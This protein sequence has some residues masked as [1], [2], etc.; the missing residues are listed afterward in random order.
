[1]VTTRKQLEPPPPPSQPKNERRSSRARKPVELLVTSQDW[2]EKKSTQAALKVNPTITKAKNGKKVRAKHKGFTIHVLSLDFLVSNAFFFFPHSF[3]SRIITITFLIHACIPFHSSRNPNRVLRNENK[4]QQHHL[5]GDGERAGTGTTTIGTASA[6]SSLPNSWS[7]PS[8]ASRSGSGTRIYRT[9]RQRRGLGGRRGRDRA[10]SWSR[11]NRCR[12]ALPS[13]SAP[14]RP[15]LSWKSGS[16]PGTGAGPGGV[17]PPSWTVVAPPKVRTLS[18]TGPA[19]GSNWRPFR[20]LWTRCRSRLDS[21]DI[22]PEVEPDDPTAVGKLSNY[23]NHQGR[24]WYAKQK[25]ETR[26]RTKKRKRLWMHICWSC[27]ICSKG[28]F[29]A[30]RCWHGTSDG[31]FLSHLSAIDGFRRS[32]SRLRR[33][34]RLGSMPSSFASKRLF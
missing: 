21:R 34:N 4:K 19:D 14:R 24:S 16:C 20:T 28:K 7:I 18:G 12:S 30:C 25:T 15:C 3:H 23:M 32:V 1:M 9:S 31:E 11:C 22:T 17:S 8:P 26:R 2:T 5:V 13:T 27:T 6:G 29:R 10:G 33:E